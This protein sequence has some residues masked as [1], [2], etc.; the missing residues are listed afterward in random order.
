MNTSIENTIRENQKA[1]AK[2]VYSRDSFYSREVVSAYKKI[3][4]SNLVDLSS[5]V[6]RY[7]DLLFEFGAIR[8]SGSRFIVRQKGIPIKPTRRACC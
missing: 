2:I 6:E 1:L 8:K 4:K 5:T 3:R 7:L